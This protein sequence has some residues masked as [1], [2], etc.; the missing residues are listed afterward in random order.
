MKTNLTTFPT[1]ERPGQAVDYMLA[2]LRWKEAFEIEINK[3]LDAAKKA[4][5]NAK[6]AKHKMAKE[7]QPWTLTY[8]NARIQTLEAILQGKDDFVFRAD[9]INLRVVDEKR[10]KP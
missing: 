3:E 2:M 7:L 9:I 5:E 4:F 1:D 10:E 8:L 6:N